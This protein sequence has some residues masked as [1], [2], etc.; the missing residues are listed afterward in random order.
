MDYR[1]QGESS[2][3]AKSKPIAQC[4]N[5]ESLCDLVVNEWCK[6]MQQ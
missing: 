3:V 4:P 6:R 5:T 2:E 1:Q